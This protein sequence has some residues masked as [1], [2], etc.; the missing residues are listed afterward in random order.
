MSE[1]APQDPAPGSGVGLG[2]AGAAAA[3]GIAAD[4][5]RAGARGTARRSDGTELPTTSC[6]DEELVVV[7][8]DGVAAARRDRRA[9]GD[10]PRCATWCPT[11]VFSPRLLLSLRSW[12]FQRRALPRPA[13][14][15][16]SGTSAATAGRDREQ[17]VGHTIDQLGRD[18]PAVIAEAA[19]EGPL[20][21]VGHSMGG[22]T[23]MA[24]AVR[25][26]RA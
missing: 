5:L 13:T 17:G 10:A 1:P 18:L 4:R 11:V 2:A 14:A 6:A 26:P 3:A 25:P 21:L 19:P 7:A 12:V 8:D 16:S 24:L 23:M 20:V 22:M 15:S 9:P